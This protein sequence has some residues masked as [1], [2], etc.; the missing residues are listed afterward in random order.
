MQTL[1]QTRPYSSG[2]EW[3]GLCPTSTVNSQD[4]WSIPSNILILIN[5][6]LTFHCLSSFTPSVYI[7][8]NVLARYRY[9]INSQYMLNLNYGPGFSETLYIHYLIGSEVTA[10]YH[11]HI[12]D[13]R[14]RVRIGHI[15]R[16]G[17]W[18]GKNSHSK[19]VLSRPLLYTGSQSNLCPLSF[20]N[21][22]LYQHLPYH[23]AFEEFLFIS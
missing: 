8:S 21:L 18:W 13:K 11:F 6:L 19:D 3:W 12:K 7:I 1:V 5:Q 16:R 2:Q 15:M 22:T 9:H 20:L 23:L 4:S 10:V 17:K 14:T